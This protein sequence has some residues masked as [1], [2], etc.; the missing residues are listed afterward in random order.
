M[1][2]GTTAS[3]PGSISSPATVMVDPKPTPAAFGSC[4]YSG[5]AR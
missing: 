1:L 2:A 5:S 3:M 4:A